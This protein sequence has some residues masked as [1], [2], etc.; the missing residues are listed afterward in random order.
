MAGVLE[1]FL[2]R[3]GVLDPGQTPMAGLLSLGNSLRNRKIL[4]NPKNALRERAFEIDEDARRFLASSPEEQTMT[5]AG[6]FSPGLA[7]VY[8]GSPHKFAKFDSSKIGT[9]EGAQAYGHGLYFAEN[10]KVAGEYQKALTKTGMDQHSN[11]TAAQLLKQTK[12]DHAA[13]LELVD[14]F[15]GQ[16]LNGYQNKAKNQQVREIL[17]SKRDP[18]DGTGSLYKVDLPDEHIAKML[19]WDKPLSGQTPEVQN[20]L[21]TAGLAVPDYHANLSGE[22][23]YRMRPDV[24]P[25]E[26]SRRMREAGIPGIKYL[27]QGSRTP[28]ASSLTPAQLDARVTALKADIASGG[29]NQAKMRADLKSLET[30]RANYRPQTSNYVAFRDDILKILERK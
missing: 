11:L 4:Q 22:S 8:H 26:V 25:A 21:R 15:E 7:T 29:G 20:A 30:E 27:D 3:Q 23:I 18:G 6:A 28:G 19:D 10:P 16:F 9:G 1:E 14:R 13:A 5:V 17:Q 12:G 24:P 2:Q